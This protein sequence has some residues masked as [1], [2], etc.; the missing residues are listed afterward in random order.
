MSHRSERAQ[1]TAELA[2]VLPLV[3]IVLLVAMQVVLVMRDAVALTSAARAGARRAMVDP[4]PGMVRA[5]VT[6]ETALVTRR[7]GVDIAGGAGAGD[8]VTVTV[9]YRSP[10]DVPIVG[11]FV[12]DVELR[13]RFTVLRE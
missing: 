3:V 8:M 13:E 11:A 12:G 1:A 9:T 10:T 5:A 7:F 4:S 6:G 2:L